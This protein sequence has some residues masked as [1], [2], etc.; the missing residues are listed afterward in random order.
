MAAA[1]DGGGLADRLVE[2]VTSLEGVGDSVLGI[3]TSM[4]GV[5]DMTATL[6]RAG[7]SLNSTLTRLL[8]LG[9]G[10]LPPPAVLSLAS[11]IGRATTPQHICT[12]I[13]GQL[14]VLTKYFGRLGDTSPGGAE[15]W[16][17]REEADEEG[18]GG[19]G[20]D[21]WLQKEATH[22]LLGAGHRAG[23]V[24]GTRLR[25]HRPGSCQEH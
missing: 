15:T 23:L 19:G 18:R 4:E 10:A 21:G 3:V 11:V 1:E 16:W 13:V 20:Q 5:A 7:E 25:V 24:G 6:E 8:D 14:V 22:A 2:V 17:C 9:P 12:W